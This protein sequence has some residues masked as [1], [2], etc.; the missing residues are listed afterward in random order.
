MGLAM[1]SEIKF[2]CLSV[3]QNSFPNYPSSDTYVCA[4]TLLQPNDLGGNKF[5]EAHDNMLIHN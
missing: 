5:V 2:Y 4:E 1:Q 3:A